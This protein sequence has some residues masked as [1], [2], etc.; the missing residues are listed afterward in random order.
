MNA[1]EFLSIINNEVN[2]RFELKLE[3]DDFA[4]IDY[5]L[6]DNVLYFLHTEV[7]DAY[8]G[9]GIAG[10]MAKFALEYAKNKGWKIKPWCPYIASYLKRHP[11]YQSLVLES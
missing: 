7:P 2:N 4:F 8:S 11:E 9:R 10:R 5:R 3:K 1:V 6:R